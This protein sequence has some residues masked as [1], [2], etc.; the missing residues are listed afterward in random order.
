MK[1]DYNIQ[2]RKQSQ[3]SFQ[4]ISDNNKTQNVKNEINEENSDFSEP[5]EVK[6]Y[7]QKQVDRYREQISYY[8]DKE[9]EKDGKIK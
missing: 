1:S 7:L 2:T 6:N 3:S 9:N 5:I 8:K 4:T